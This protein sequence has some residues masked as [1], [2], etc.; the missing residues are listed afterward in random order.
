[1]CVLTGKEIENRAGDIFTNGSWFLDSFQEASYDLRVDTGPYL[2]IGGKLYDEANPYGESFIEIKPGELALIPTIE[3]FCMPPDLVGDIK[4]KFSHSRQG[5]TP[6]FGPKIDP[7]FGTGL[8]DERLYLWVSN[9]GLKSIVIEKGEP[10]FTVQFH[11][12][13]G[14]PPAPS[15]KEPVGPRVAREIRKMGTGQYLGF[16][17]TIEAEVKKEFESRLNRVEEGTQ[18]VVTFGV[19]LV[20]SAL[21][22]G[23]LG[24]IFATVSAVN[25][26]SGV[27]AFH[28]LEG[29]H[30]GNLLFALC[31]GLAILVFVLI[32]AAVFKLAYPVVNS[33]RKRDDAH[34]A[35]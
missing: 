6:L 26:K 33:F 31:V 27:A 10:V 17:D 32:L 29:S 14:E 25:T 2:R 8:E 13:V 1:M 19:F 24:A 18:Q 3:S 5:L 16:L 34:G 22:A 9:L 15:Q 30:W 35:Q 11:K 12:L 28:A 21:F 7:M 20:A 23:V 4:I